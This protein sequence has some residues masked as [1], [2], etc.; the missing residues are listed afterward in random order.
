[1]LQTKAG[2]RRWRTDSTASSGTSSRSR[3]KPS[4]TCLIAS[5]LATSLCAKRRWVL[6]DLRALT[7]R[8]FGGGPAVS[9]C[10]PRP[11]HHIA[12]AMMMSRRGLEGR[13]WGVCRRTQNG[14][15]K[16]PM[17]S[18]GLVRSDRKMEPFRSRVRGEDGPETAVPAQRS[19]V[20][21]G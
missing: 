12:M 16:P 6:A 4:T 21:A 7:R 20:M 1:M 8:S 19:C 2:Q 3:F 5:A 15:S 18:T 9:P 17:V 11:L 14:S 13:G 10:K